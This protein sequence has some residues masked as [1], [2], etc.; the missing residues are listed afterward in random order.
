MNN[1]YNLVACGL[2]YSTA[3]VKALK[4]LGIKFYEDID[5]N[6]NLYRYSD[7]AGVSVTLNWLT[8]LQVLANQYGKAVVKAGSDTI[9][10]YEKA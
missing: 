6:G 3:K 7:R 5:A 1:K 10:I 4:K 9:E 8:D 2:F